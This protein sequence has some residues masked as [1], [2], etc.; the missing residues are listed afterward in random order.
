MLFIPR[1][2]MFLLRK[3]TGSFPLY[4]I[5][6]LNPAL[7]LHV[8]VLDDIC[9]QCGYLNYSLKRLYLCASYMRIHT[10]LHTFT[11]YTLCN[12]MLALYLEK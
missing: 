11:G 1:D 9:K 10:R 3:Q 12:T 7:L 2:A 5:F 6:F 4:A 8:E